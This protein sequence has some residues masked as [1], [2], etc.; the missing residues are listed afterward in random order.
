MNPFGQNL[1]ST[2]QKTLKSGNSA[3]PH[4]RVKKKC[5]PPLGGA[6]PAPVTKA[7]QNFADGNPPL[8]VELCRVDGGVTRNKN[9]MAHKVRGVIQM[10]IHL[11][12]RC[13]C[14]VYTQKILCL[15]GID[16]CGW[17]RRA[18]QVVLTSSLVD[19]TSGSGA[20]ED[21]AMTV[22]AID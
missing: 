17:C 4:A 10:V 9:N 22:V 16:I 15:I 5:H 1:T 14:S 11:K 2:V 8:R 20:T 13:P 12:G 21:V 19:T 6:R 7:W 18:K 3:K